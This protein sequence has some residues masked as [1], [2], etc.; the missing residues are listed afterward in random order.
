MIAAPASGSGKT[1]LS[2]GIMTALKLRGLV[3]QPYKAG[4]DFIDPAWHEKATDRASINLDTWMT[5]SSFVKE[6]FGRNLDGADVAVVEG[7]M[8]LFDGIGENREDGS[9]AQL[10]KLLGIP[11]ILVVD[12][13]AFSRSAGAL[14]L[15]FESFDRQLRVAGVIFNNVAGESHYRGLCAAVK[16]SCRAEVL[17]ALPRIA[18]IKLPERQ[19]GL[20]SVHEHGLGKDYRNRLVSAINGHVDLDRLLE[21]SA[22]VVTPP[23]A[24]VSESPEKVRIAIARDPAFCFYYEDNLR[25]LRQAGAELAPFSPIHDKLLPEGVCGIYLGGGFPEE[26]AEEL[27]GNKSMRNAIRG[28]NGPVIAE[29]GG[30]IYLCENHIGKDG[31]MRKMAGRI[32]GTIE[33]TDK[34]QRLG[35]CEA[36]FTRDT[37]LG[38]AGEVLRGHRFHWSAWKDKPPTGWGVFRSQ[39]EVF[40]YSDEMTLASFFHFHLGSRPESAA[41]FVE[42]CRRA[43][44]SSGKDIP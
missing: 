37:I 34:L 12:A 15:G 31:I 29:C 40:G 4:P 41:Q 43:K 9:S 42:Q 13:R 38:R 3:V 5:P 25:L 16:G 21:L 28:F 44:Q 11:V 19:L 35:Y 20:S 27:S 18:E 39:D 24:P 8:G 17:G 10:A 30:L 7:V 26:F 2:I 23:P 36:T 33:M 14:V 32:P 1:T 22:A 6:S